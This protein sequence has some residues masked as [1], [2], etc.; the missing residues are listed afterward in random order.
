MDGWM[1]K[2]ISENNLVRLE[3]YTDKKSLAE[4][5][6]NCKLSRWTS[7]IDCTQID[8][9]DG[10][11]SCRWMDIWIVIIIVYGCVMLWFSNRYGP[12]EA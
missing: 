4:W 8:G 7:W 2:K 5:I 1:A 3:G 9:C 12:L 10:Y 11:H 6:A